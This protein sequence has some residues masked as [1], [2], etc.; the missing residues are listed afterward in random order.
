MTCL[1]S[2]FFKMK[3][4]VDI[5]IYSVGVAEEGSVAKDTPTFS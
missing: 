2:M 4:D 3:G 1:P 5:T